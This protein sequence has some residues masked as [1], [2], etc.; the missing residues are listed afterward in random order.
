M[1]GDRQR[2]CKHAS[3]I[4]ERCFLCGLSCTRCYAARIKDAAIIETVFSA[5]SVPKVYKRHGK[6]LGAV[7]FRRTKR[8]GIKRSTT[9]TRELKF[10]AQKLY[11]KIRE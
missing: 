2:S 8:M 4:E 6:S 1:P 7:E 5:L 11:N 3:L 10:K 9:E